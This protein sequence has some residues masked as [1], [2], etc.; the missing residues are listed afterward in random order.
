MTAIADPSNANAS[1]RW[2]PTRGATTSRCSPTIRDLL[3][4]GLVNAVVVATPT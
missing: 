4:S 1:S 3:A 2:Q